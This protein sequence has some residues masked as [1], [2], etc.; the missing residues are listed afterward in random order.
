[1]PILT[2]DFHNTLVECDEW[3][4]LE[5]RTLVSDVLDWAESQGA[6][7]G[8]AV[9]RQQVDGLYRKLRLAIHHHGHEVNAYRSV[10]TVLGRLGVELPDDVVTEAVDSVMA[11]ALHHATPVRGAGEL[12][13]SIRETGVP[14]AVVSSAVHHDFLEWSLER[15]G[16]REHIEIV[17]TSASAGFYKSRPEIYWTALAA[18]GQPASSGVHLGDSLR[19]DVGG[20]Q[21]AGMRSIWFDRKGIGTGR[22]EP[23]MPQLVVT[24]LVDAHEPVMG[25]LHAN[26]RC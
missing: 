9:P 7:P 24:D 8:V 15:F 1:M 2:I 12:I 17:V 13:K 6:S 20:A 14:I 23:H 5:V 10:V 21:Q 26:G 18:L 11:D 4:E 25:V 22:D 3:F 19:F 16:M